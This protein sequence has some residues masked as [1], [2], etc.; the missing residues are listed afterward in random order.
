M[1]GT[2]LDGLDLVDVTIW[3]Q[4]NTWNFRL[5]NT[6]FVPYSKEYQTAL[7]ECFDASIQVVERFSHDY[8]VFL[9]KAVLQF[10]EKYGIEKVDLLASHGHT[11]FHKPEERFTLQIG[12]GQVLS[13]LT[14]LKV[15]CDFRTQDVAL[16]GQGAPL[17][18]I[19]DQL[20]FNNYDYCLNLGGFANVSFNQN[21]VRKAY[22]I[23]P[24]NTVLNHYVR[25]LGMEYDDQGKIAQSGLIN[26]ALFKALNKLAFYAA[27]YPKSLGYEFVAN[28]VLPL[29][30]SYESQ[31]PNIL[32]TVVEH[33]VFQLSESFKKETGSVLITGGGAYNSFLINH[34][35]AMSSLEIIIPSKD[36]VDFK[37]AL[38]FALLG[39]LK[40]KGKINVLSS[41]TGASKDHSAGKI[42][43]PQQRI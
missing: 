34:L 30:D 31:V 40:E 10:R 4:Q 17:V 32:R 37:E 38:I 14:G 41:V 27:P 5:H 25:K 23:C 22:D 7:K 9:A 16:G 13:D 12:D 18:P 24:V 29:I 39:Y 8:G 33:I 6:W 42:Y 26:E 19:G 35:R 2:S 20:F 43:E 1:S 28:T 11:I 36:L 3:Q 21:G 15:V